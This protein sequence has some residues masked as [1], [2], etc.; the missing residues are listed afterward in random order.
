[1]LIKH[2]QYICGFRFLNYFVTA[3]NKHYKTSNVS[4]LLLIT[5]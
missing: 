1:M 3:A 2:I 5:S 4:K